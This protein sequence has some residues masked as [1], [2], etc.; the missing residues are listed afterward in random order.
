[1]R[2]YIRKRETSCASKCTQMWLRTVFAVEEVYG[3]MKGDI[4]KD[5]KYGSFIMVSFLLRK[6]GFTPSSRESFYEFL[7]EGLNAF[8]DQFGRYATKRHI[9]WN[10]FLF[11]FNDCYIRN[12]RFVLAYLRDVEEIVS[13]DCFNYGFT[14]EAS[15]YDK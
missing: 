6:R 9:A 11:K 10:Q 7:L 5:E 4:F 8:E 12:A 3:S 14:P 1:M 15:F 2:L 13:I